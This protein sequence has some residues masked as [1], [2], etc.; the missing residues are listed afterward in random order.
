MA[1]LDECYV[2]LGLPPFAGRADV[3][4][5]YRLLI[6]VWHPDRFEHQQRIREQAEEHLKQINAAFKQIESAGFPERSG[7]APGRGAGPAPADRGERGVCACP[8]CDVR[9]RLP[10]DY[11]SQE[12]TC[13]GCRG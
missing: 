1:T 2:V 6:Q 8:W 3:S 5:K 7:P 9:N 13:G 10:A 12:V 11:R 4:A